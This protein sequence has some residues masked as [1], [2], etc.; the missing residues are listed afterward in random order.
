MKL[1]KPSRR[2]ILQAGGVGLLNLA[3]PGLV[4]GKD[5]F[6]TSGCVG[7]GRCITPELCTES[8]SSREL[9]IDSPPRSPASITGL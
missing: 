1:P 8:S 7:C 2:R 3:V 6:D 9:A 4:V 5:Q